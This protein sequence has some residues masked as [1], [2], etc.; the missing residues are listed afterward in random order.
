MLK[1]ISAALFFLISAAFTFPVFAGPHRIGNGGNG[2]YNSSK[3]TVYFLDFYEAG[4]EKEAFFNS[5]VENI[6]VQEVEAVLPADVFPTKMIA[7]KISEIYALDKVTGASLLSAL[8]LFSWVFINYEL[9]KTTDVATSINLKDD[10]LLQIAN[11]RYGQILI[12]KPFWEKMSDDSKAGLVLHELIYSLSSKDDMDDIQVNIIS[13]SIVGRIFS[14]TFKYTDSFNLQSIVCTILPCLKKQLP[15]DWR[16]TPEQYSE[17][18]TAMPLS[19]V[20]NQ[21]AFMPTVDNSGQSL[22]ISAIDKNTL[23]LTSA[24]RSLCSFNLNYDISANYWVNTYDLD[25]NNMGYISWKREL[26]FASTTSDLHSICI[27]ETH[28]S[29]FMSYAQE[30]LKPFWNAQ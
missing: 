4:I 14:S 9:E 21:V 5:A 3:D 30:S 15:Q 27:D 2:L 11:R 22:L 28:F 19:M 7:A 20:G 6:F 17:Y 26:I 8:R 29:L 25:K 18:N 1:I 10:D 23:A 24:V 12:H 13:R 16:L